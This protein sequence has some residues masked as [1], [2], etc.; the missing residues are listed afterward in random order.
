M[1]LK[2]LRPADGV[3]MKLVKYDLVGGADGDT[4]TSVMYHN[5]ILETNNM[6]SL[7]GQSQDQDPGHV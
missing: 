1:N 5:H 3:M 6:G 2:V 4:A 7:K